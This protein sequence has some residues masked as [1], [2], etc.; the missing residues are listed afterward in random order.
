MS[1]EFVSDRISKLSP[2]KRLLLEKLLEQQKKAVGSVSQTIARRVHEAPIPL[3]F[4]QHRL[5]FMQ[6]VEP[7]SSAYHIVRTLR[8]SGKLH[9]EA[10]HQSLAT[11][12][13][14]HESL[15]TRF[16]I[17]NGAPFQVITSPDG[18]E[19]PLIDLS[20]EY[21]QAEETL[22]ELLHQKV[23]QPFDLT[24]DLMLR[25]T[26]FRLSEDEYVLQIIMHHIASDG[27]SVG[28]LMR[29]LSRLYQAYANG[30]PNPLSELPIQYTDFALW[31]RQWLQGDTL[32]TQL[33]YWKYHLA[34][35]PALLDLPTDYPRS[36]QTS[37]QGTRL[38]FSLSKHLT[39]SLKNLSQQTD[40]TLFMTLLAAFNILLYRYSQQ[41][42]IVIG[43]PIA[44]RNRSEL[45][46]LIGFFVN[47]L[48][49]RTDL[50]N[51]PSFRNLLERVR[52]VT[53]DAYS[54]QDIPFEDLVAELKPVRSQNHSPWFQVFFAF[55]NFP[56]RLLNL[57]GVETFPQKFKGKDN[58]MFDLSLIIYETGDELTGKLV[59]KTDLF[60]EVT[61]GRMI[62]QFKVL[63][64]AIV[65]NP[66]QSVSELPLLTPA[67]RQQLLTQG[68]LIQQDLPLQQC[69]HQ[70]FEAQV[71]RTPEAVAVVWNE[72]TFSYQVL[73]ARANQLA[74]HLQALGV[75]P[76]NLVG[77]CVDRSFDMVVS[78]L[79][80]LKVGGCYVPLDPCYPTERLSLMMADA[81]L[82]VLLTQERW[83]NNLDSQAVH[84]I[85]LDRDC[86][87][88]ATQSDHNLT[89]H[90]TPEHLAYII[91]TSGSTGKPKGVMVPHHA[92]VNF[93]QAAVD[94][95]EIH[96]NDRILQFASISF[97]AAAE[98]IYPCLISG[99]TLMLR[100]E[101]MIGSVSRF[102]ETCRNWQISVLDLPTAFWQ[103]L[104]PEL[105][106]G[107]VSLPKSL[108]LV[109]I[110]GERVSPE[111]VKTWQVDVGD[112]PK[113]INT[114]GPT[115]GTVVAT[116][117]PITAKT[118]ISGEVPIGQPIANVETYVLDSH[119]Q[120]VPIGVPGE[121]YIGGR[122]LAQGY[123]N[124]PEL[125]AER[126][127]SNPFKDFPQAKIYKTGDKVRYLPEG[128]LEF[129]GRIDNQVK[130]RGYR[131]EL[132]EIESSLTKHS[133]VQQAVVI[134]RD[135]PSG[136]KQLIAYV[137]PTIGAKP[138]LK[139]L[140]QALERQLP[141]YMLPSAIVV[142]EQ[143]PLSPNGKVDRKALPALEPAQQR[144]ETKFVAPRTPIEEKLSQIWCD[145]L[146]LEQVGIHDNFFELGGHS[147]KAVQIVARIQDQLGLAITIQHLFGFPTIAKLI[148]YCAIVQISRDL[149]IDSSSVEREEIEI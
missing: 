65:S 73:N 108:R 119:L 70:L 83:L 45:E 98:E 76:G 57:Q 125:T 14:R 52:Q 16:V 90:I 89:A 120:P 132:G 59:Y 60:E 35:A 53:L 18:F 129:L 117:F 134:D 102:L 68:H 137:V 50:S 64:E 118:F 17:T 86:S 133:M 79:S 1:S 122:G 140:R 23:N 61:I 139:E 71:E 123:L 33:D 97:D 40:V 31:Q 116:A 10:L 75:V 147:L 124:Q 49:L 5:W 78:L 67:E 54:H 109:I 36:L 44:N 149:Q 138:V 3:S 47:S 82:R 92:L 101:D 34:G 58:A 144:S 2:V 6:Q 91:Y 110:G 22:Q 8:L 107:T 136:D 77:V 38:N 96:Q 85:C 105:A 100:T 51:N 93:T 94:L 130:I 39:D 69:I 72:Q 30:Q 114:Y 27:W 99:G 142:L 106:A 127:I 19:L 62:S 74:R 81:R 46:S 84:T 115:E 56:P 141:H 32:Q 28:V 126:F 43:S 113:L 7:K 131:V 103:Q 48:V 111:C 41:E 135:E 11:I 88:I 9:V 66:N 143:L 42:D 21:E 145:L 26:L 25:A 4:V 104:V 121:L 146:N 80:I 128:Q 55:Q 20:Y 112:T 12:L 29:E 63:L 15:R 13:A 87:N 148:E 95:Y 24:S 37:S